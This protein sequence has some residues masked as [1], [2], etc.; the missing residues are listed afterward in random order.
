MCGAVLTRAVREAT[1]LKVQEYLLKGYNGARILE[2]VNHERIEKGERPLRKNTIYTYIEELKQIHNK[3]YLELLKDQTAYVIL[4]RQKLLALDL[5]KKMIHDKIALAGG[6]S[7]IKPDTLNRL[8]MTL[9][10]ITVSQSRLEREIPHL[11]NIT[12]SKSPEELHDLENSIVEGL[13]KDL[14]DQFWKEEKRKIAIR[15][16]KI[17]QDPNAGYVNL[18]EFK[19]DQFVI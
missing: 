3:W 18:S 19:S 2:I 16:Q 1:K 15:E 5:Y 10:S 4:H 9:T 6:L 11:F 7:A 8:V 17:I 14:R 12:N 13:P